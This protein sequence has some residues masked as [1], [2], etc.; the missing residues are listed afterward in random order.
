MAEVA[1]LVDWPIVDNPR[2]RSTDRGAE[3]FSSLP[4]VS[5]VDSWLMVDRVE[6]ARAGSATA[7]DT[8]GFTLTAIPVTLPAIACDVLGYRPVP[9]PL[10]PNFGA[11]LRPASVAI[12][13]EA[14]RDVLPFVVAAVV[15]LQSHPYL[16]YIRLAAA[17]GFGDPTYIVTV[18]FRGIRFTVTPQLRQRISAPG[19]RLRGGGSP[20]Q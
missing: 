4:V 11:G 14:I 1:F 7:A 13:V 12:P 5:V 9:A 6:T 15:F 16:D 10:A 19:D 18:S 20:G 3:D 2:H 8:D 17:G